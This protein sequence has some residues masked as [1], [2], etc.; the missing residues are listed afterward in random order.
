MKGNRSGKHHQWLTEDVGHPM[1]SQHLYSLITL[2]RGFDD[3]K[4]FYNFSNRLYPKYDESNLDLFL[5]E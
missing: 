3:W 1:L 5:P 2:M 4:T